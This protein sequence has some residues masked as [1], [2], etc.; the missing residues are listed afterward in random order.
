MFLLL[1]FSNIVSCQSKTKDGNYYEKVGGLKLNYTIKGKGPIMIV[2]HLSSGKIGYE[3]TLKPLEKFFTM[4]Y[5][6]PRGTGKSETPKTIEE[7]NQDFIVQ[8]IEDLRKNL[9]ADKIFIFGHSDQ[10]SIA[11]EYALKFPQNTY[12][13]ILTGTSLVGTQ[14]ETFNRRKKSEIQ[15]AKES[16]WFSQVIKDWD[17]MIENKTQKNEI[18]E[19][20]SDA[21]IKWWCYNE[22]SSKK[23]IPIVKEISKSGRRRPIKEVYAVETETERRKYLDYQK[24]FPSIKTSILIING[25]FDTNNPPKYAE[26]LHKVLPNSKFV[27]IDKAGHFPWIENSEKTFREIENWINTENK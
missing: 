24:L 8:E 6:E 10:S 13:L 12:G 11:L 14:Q 19:D 1:T 16:K 27:L 26:K 3:L 18:G 5:Y 2:G 4:V 17:F 25:K 15:R 20:I 23:V 22:E 9:K 7:Y 21:P